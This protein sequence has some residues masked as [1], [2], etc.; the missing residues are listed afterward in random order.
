MHERVPEKFFLSTHLVFSESHLRR[1]LFL[2]R[3][4][5]VIDEFG[6]TFGGTTHLIHRESGGLIVCDVSVV[7]QILLPFCFVFKARG[8]TILQHSVYLRLDAVCVP[9][10]VTSMSQS[11]QSPRKEQRNLRSAQSSPL[12]RFQA[13]RT[14]AG[15]GACPS[16]ACSSR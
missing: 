13:D 12:S 11:A 8:V 5:N 4:I 6:G 15:G 2:T 1:R 9:A 14:L 7:F 10:V 16:R 3:C